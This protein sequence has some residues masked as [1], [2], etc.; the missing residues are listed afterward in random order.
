MHFFKQLKSAPSY[1]LLALLLYTLLW[2]IPQYTYAN[3][4]KEHSIE[5]VLDILSPPAR[6]NRV[7]FAKMYAEV[8]IPDLIPGAPNIG[9][10][11]DVISLANY[12]IVDVDMSDWQLYTDNNG[13]GSPVFTFPLGTILSPCQEVFIVND[14]LGG[15]IGI[16]LPTDWFDGNFSNS[17]GFF[18]DDDDAS[19]FA[20]LRDPNSNNYISIH[21][22]TQP[23]LLPIGTDLGDINL[24]PLIPDNFDSCELAYWEDNANQYAIITSCMVPAF[25]TTCLTT[26]I[27]SVSN[28]SGFG[29]SCAGGDNGW[30]KAKALGGTPPYNFEWRNSTDDII[31]SGAIDSIFDLTAGLYR[32]IISDAIGVIGSYQTILQEP[33]MLQ[34]QTQVLL[35][36][37]GQAISCEGAMDGSAF[38]F[39]FSG[40]V[41]QT[42]GAPPYSYEWSNGQTTDTLSNVGAGMYFVTTTDANGCTDLDSVLINDP[43]DWGVEITQTSSIPCDGSP[44]GQIQAVTTGTIGSV[45]YTW[46]TGDI[47]SVLSGLGAGEY[48]VVARSAGG[49]ERRDTFILSAPPLIDVDFTHSLPSACGVNDG[50]I[51]AE[52]T[53][54]TPPYNFVQ[55]NTGVSG[56]TLPNVTE[57]IYTLTVVDVLGCSTT[58]PFTLGDPDCDVSGG[59]GTCAGGIVVNEIF[60]DG[61]TGA[62]WIELLVVGDPTDPTAAVNL[63]GWLVD[64]NNGDYIRDSGPSSM[65]QG[66]LGFGG[67]WSS[68]PPGTVI[69]IYDENN[70]DTDLP[71]DDPIDFN[72]DGVRILPANHFSFYGCSDAPNTTD[73]TYGFCDGSPPSWSFIELLGESDVVQTISIDKS[74]FHAVSWGNMIA[75]FPITSC[76][77]ETIHVDGA[78]SGN[79]I[80]FSCGDWTNPTKYARSNEI[81]KTAG[82]INSSRNQTTADLLN[83][84]SF[85]YADPDNE[86]HCEESKGT[87]GGDCLPG[88]IVNELYINNAGTVSWIE[89]LV[90]GGGSNVNDPVNL[91]GWIIDDNN[92]EFLR[93]GTPQG[94]S[95][96]AL[97]LGNHWSAVMPGSIIL[98]Y[99]EAIKDDR[100]PLDDFN[101]TNGDGIFV[102]PGDH[103]SLYGCSDTPNT[104]DPSYD[105]CTIAPP[106]WSFI[107]FQFRDAVQVRTPLGLFFHGYAFGDFDPPTLEFACGGTT[108]SF[109]LPLNNRPTRFLCGDWYDESNY[110]QPGGGVRTPAG[111]NSQGNLVTISKIR[112][113]DFDYANPNDPIHCTDPTITDLGAG[114]CSQGPGV[115]IN[116]LS[117]GLVDDREWVEFIVL[118]DP[119]NPTGFVDLEGW[120]FDDNNGEF[121]LATGGS[122]ITSGALGFGSSWGSV[123]PGSIIVIYNEDNK[124]PDIP[125]DDPDDSNGDNVYILP[126]NHFS[127]FGC[128]DAPTPSNPSYITCNGALPTWA[129]VDIDNDGDAFQVRRPSK[130]FFQGFSFGNIGSTFPTNACSESSFGFPEAE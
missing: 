65:T 51:I 102:I 123:T 42:T 104:G 48:S 126:G 62:S 39:S 54:G 37:E 76:D 50:Q 11:L 12:G 13:T 17:E 57:G 45:E 35:P 75:P 6:L 105:N 69:L 87:R 121:Q 56:D 124:D 113:G 80:S 67:F 8:G 71:P 15:A 25:I 91:E 117:L 99:N 110:H 32:V 94:L 120:L 40:A 103:W 55:W 70:K 46:N 111:V 107:E 98:I 93:G 64:D 106:S 68:T 38:V 18:T 82:L 66:A 21:N 60:Q 129:F 119:D 49:C 101:D 73:P 4:D 34:S 90:V 52:I 2:S 9:T 31:F 83:D 74:L 58:E 72:D 36:F 28:Y 109:D 63:L 112:T 27:E 29:I 19:N 85:N 43:P 84:G 115:V 5:N 81:N 10:T 33:V 47:G 130:E 79:T 97:G 24:S 41:D 116:E 20:I 86:I 89:L 96:G 61:T 78:L 128:S 95:Q 88:V 14:W 114:V 44:V 3:S 122:E 77:D 30:I 53:G 1:S 118:G 7:G 100:I 125:A 22:L 26:D 108:W 16:P 92:G 59:G 23:P 127:L